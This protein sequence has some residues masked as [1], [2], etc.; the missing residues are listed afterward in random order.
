MDGEDGQPIC[1]VSLF[2]VLG[3]KEHVIERKSESEFY[4]DFISFILLWFTISVIVCLCM[5]VLVKLNFG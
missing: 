4:S 3:N 5:Y 1:P 2:S